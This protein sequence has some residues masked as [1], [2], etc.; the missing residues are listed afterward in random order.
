MPPSRRLVDFEKAAISA[1]K[2]TSSRIKTC[3]FYSHLFGVE[4]DFELKRFYVRNADFDVVAETI[5]TLVF[6]PIVDIEKQ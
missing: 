6:S 4:A 2:H 5:S 1:F 3:S